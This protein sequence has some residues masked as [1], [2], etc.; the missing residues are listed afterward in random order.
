MRISVNILFEVS[1][2][3][4]FNLSGYVVICWLSIVDMSALLGNSFELSSGTFAWLQHQNISNVVCKIQLSV[5]YVLTS[6]SLNLVVI[7][8]ID[9]FYATYFPFKYKVHATIS[10]ANKVSSGGVA[11]AVITASPFIL[12]HEMGQNP[13]C[14]G[15][16]NWLTSRGLLLIILVRRIF[17]TFIPGLVMIVLNCLMIF[18]LVVNS[19]TKR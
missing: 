8:S 14:F 11:L 18:R 1:Q 13:N 12:L 4:D 2:W 5:F 19:R 16:A 3:T 6:A 10:N 17:M 15:P 7:L 9:R